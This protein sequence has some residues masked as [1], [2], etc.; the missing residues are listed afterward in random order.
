[1]SQIELSI[2]I[3]TMN[4]SDQLIEAIESC[5]KCS[6]PVST[7]FVILNNAST[8][9][10]EQVIHKLID[11]NPDANI[12]YYYSDTNLG[13][14]GGRGYVFDKAC[15]KYVY[16]MD[17]DAIIAPECADSFFIDSIAFLKKHNHVASLTTRI[18][19]EILGEQRNEIASD[20]LVDGKN[21]MFFYLGGSHFLKKDCFS[22]PLYMKIMYGLEEYAPSIRAIDQG[23]C[24]VFDGT[25]CIIH[26]PKV[27]K[28]IDGSERIKK[29]Q[30]AYAAVG[31]ATKKLL[32]P[33]IFLPI[34]WGCYQLRCAKYLRPYKGAQKEADEMV[35]KIVRENPLPKV[36]I[37]T[38]LYMFKMFG[39]TVF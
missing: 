20:H 3:I 10:T 23:Y 18:R 6:M 11:E 32:Y 31:Y 25:L 14:G 19:D 8:D 36:K 9:D 33:H 2:A 37:R 34:L 17:D 29:V 21:L 26:K 22:S 12:R 27:N 28:W 4:R 30:I 16:F 7:E 24:H 13:V 38:V 39:M 5:L 35:R 15:G 1:M